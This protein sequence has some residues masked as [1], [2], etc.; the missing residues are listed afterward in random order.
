MANTADLKKASEWGGFII[1]EARKKMKSDMVNGVVFLI[2]YAV[3]AVILALLS[4]IFIIISGEFVGSV[5]LIFLFVWVLGNGIRPI[6]TARRHYRSI[7]ERSTALG[8]EDYWKVCF[9]ITQR[10]EN[11]GHF[12]CGNEWLYSPFGIL[13]R[14][15]DICE[16]NSDFFYGN[17]RYDIHP[18]KRIVFRIVLK[19]GEVINSTVTDGRDIRAVNEGFDGFADFAKT[20]GIAISRKFI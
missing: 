1:D 7:V 19:N 11:P 4:L 6:L 9:D 5:V 14:W 10:T 2:V 20:K 13:C 18:Y 3:L 17:T 8:K 16:I 15:E 12:Y